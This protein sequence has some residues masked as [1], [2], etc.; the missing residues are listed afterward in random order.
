MLVIGIFA[1]ITVPCFVAILAATVIVASGSR[2]ED[3][4][5][6]FTSERPP[7]LV[8]RVSRVIISRYVRKPDAEPPARVPEERVPR[9]ERWL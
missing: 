8:A 5:G 4:R 1:A 2:Q 7:S 3:W 9:Y 6:T